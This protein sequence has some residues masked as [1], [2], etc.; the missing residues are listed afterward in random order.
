MQI[1]I[2]VSS[3]AK[4]MEARYAGFSVAAT[5]L[6]NKLPEPHYMVSSTTFK[7]IFIPLGLCRTAIGDWPDPIFSTGGNATPIEPS[8]VACAGSLCSNEVLVLILWEKY[9]SA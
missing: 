4:R 5:C 9:A 2:V 3:E 7:N 1:K 6:W 8:A